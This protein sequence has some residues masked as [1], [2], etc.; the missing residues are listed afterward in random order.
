MSLFNRNDESRLD[1]AIAQAANEPLDPAEVEAATARV[2]QR[3][4]QGVPVATVA[5][6]SSIHAVEGPAATSGAL[7]SCADFQS[8]IPAYLRGELAPARALL[9]ED[10]ARG[11]VPCRRALREARDGKA[12]PVRPAE[13]KIAVR[14]R[15]AVWGSLAAMLLLAVGAGSFYTLQ[16]FLVSGDR[17]A[18]VENV[19]GNLFLLEGQTLRPLEAGDRLD[20]GQLVRTAKASHAML[21]M[22]DGSL[23]EMNER[24]GLELDAAREGNTIRLEGGQVIVHAAKQRPRHLFVATHDALVSVTG[25]IFSVNNGTKGTRVSVV[26]G[27]VRVKQARRDSILHP[28]DQVTTHASVAA[29]PIR[30]EIAWSENKAEYEQLLAELTALGRDIDAQVE[31]P[32]LRTSTRLLDAM[33]AGTTVYIALPNL[34]QSLAETHRILDERIDTNPLL[35]QWWSDTLGSGK[36]EDAL[37]KMIARLGDLGR[38]LGD[39]I[40]IGMVTTQDVEGHDGMPV[41]LAEVT[42]AAAF[43]AT[44]E[45][46]IAN[47]AH[48]NGNGNGNGNLAQHVVIVDNPAAVP[49]ASGNGHDRMLLWVGQ[50]VF[51]A[52]PSP[53]LL[54]Q[55][56]ASYEST[57][58]S[59][60]A[61][62]SFHDRIAESY[63]DGAGWLFAADLHTLVAE[64]HDEP[65]SQE[66]AE[67]LGI[68]DLDHFLIDRREI[69]GKVDTRAALTFDQPR[70]GI[71]S[72]LAAPAS[73]QSLR[74]FSPDANLVASFVVKNPVS[75]IDDLLTM[76]PNF[77]AELAK[78]QSEQGIDVRN[79]LAAPMGGE[80]AFGI[81]GPLVPTP[82]WKLAAE[83]YD[84]ARLQAT[85]ERL[86]QR[87]DGE[88]RR[89]N[90]G[91]AE[92]KEQTA[93]GRTY[94]T[95]SLAGG[96]SG[97]PVS[98]VYTF[99]EGFLLASPS[100]ALLDR[101]IQQRDSGVTLAS[102]AKLRDLLGPDGQVNVSALAYQNLEP[103]LNSAGRVL[104]GAATNSKPGSALRA[105][106]GHGP[107]VA[108]AYGYA[109]RIQF[110]TSSESPLGLNLETLASFGGFMGLVDE[111]HNEAAAAQGQAQA[112]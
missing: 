85:L 87:V 17:M 66:T 51:V 105:I 32:G 12:A 75:I 76:D 56:A 64:G 42:N 68:L 27:E 20:E 38:N 67:K 50:D 7:N 45:Q 11:C 101:A 31:R 3:L 41:L 18:R 39:E 49:P 69:D 37:R 55:V 4:S 72:W 40:A 14:S 57:A 21:R 86:V 15:R 109:D 93:G 61:S 33:P 112:N 96:G 60:F 91:R 110:G 95:V 46:E 2:W 63:R 70:R 53:A 52:T 16:D 23:I 6:D 13:S 58:A 1:E 29:V 26:E 62:T 22:T 79:D 100:R 88:L 36:N 77:A 54:A 9:L 28:G 98:F 104:P 48:G 94:Y 8:L 30:R 92:I 111:A 34:S 103:V 84:P 99:E 24:V 106:I 102:S 35:R 97:K 65:S 5:A 19:E 10:H 83:V 108:Y 71:A 25:T 82:S 81:D 59:P 73:M 43:R 78:L 80:F 74:F 44:L 90:K 89:E 107:T 47:A